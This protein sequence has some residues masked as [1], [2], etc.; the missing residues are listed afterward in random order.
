MVKTV[1]IVDDE[2]GARYTVKQGLE[3]LYPEFNVVPVESGE[4]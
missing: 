1:V 4:K 2:S 3:A